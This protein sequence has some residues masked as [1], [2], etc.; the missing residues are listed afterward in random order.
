[1]M[2]EGTC[3]GICSSVIGNCR[4]GGKAGK[5]EGIESSGVSRQD[6]TIVLGGLVLAIE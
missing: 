1:M 6:L 5:R 3:L 2:I 4:V